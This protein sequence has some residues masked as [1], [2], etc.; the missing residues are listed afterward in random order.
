[1]RTPRRMPIVQVA[2]EL[3]AEHLELQRVVA[4]LP[5]TLVTGP[6]I[7]LNSRTAGKLI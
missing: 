7:F 2:K 4:A 5:V 3:R 1:M 6:S